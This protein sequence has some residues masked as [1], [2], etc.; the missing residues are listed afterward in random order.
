MKLKNTLIVI[1][2]LLCMQMGLKTLSYPAEIETYFLPQSQE[3]IYNKLSTFLDKARNRVL[4]AMYWLTDEI[5]FGKLV[6]LK[7]RGIDI[8]VIFDESTPEASNHIN[9]FLVNNIVPLIA[10][11]ERNLGDLALTSGIMHNKFVVIDSNAVWTGSANFTKTVLAPEGKR[12]NDENIIIINSPIAAEEY[13]K[14][15]YSI[16]NDNIE[17]YL[18]IIATIGNLA[19]LPNWL[20]PLCQKL[21]QVNTRFEESLNSMIPQL[22]GSQQIRLRSLFPEKHR[23]E[24]PRRSFEEEATPRQKAF[25]ESHRLP[26]NISKSDA[27]KLIGEII[28]AERGESLKRTRGDWQGQYEAAAP[29]AQMRRFMPEE[30]E[31]EEEEEEM[32]TPAQQYFLRSRGISPYVSKSKASRIIGGI[33][34][35]ERR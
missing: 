9:A 14:A 34:A 24:E 12:T 33:K 1:M 3:E 20:I 16:E 19:D 35:Q 6:E 7:K 5:V 27:T 13:S 22:L 18:Q 29:A 8:Q 28:A 15:F 2:M 32:A 21:Y 26:S 17:S 4:V 25:L 30:E 31:E 11:Q 23:H 10:L